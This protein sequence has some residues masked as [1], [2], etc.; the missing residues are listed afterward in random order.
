MKYTKTYV[1]ITES[2]RKLQSTRNF[3]PPPPD[4]VCEFERIS[5]WSPCILS[6]FLKEPMVV[7]IDALATEVENHEHSVK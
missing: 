1:L 5:F 6:V 3:L 2:F 4:Y 7:T